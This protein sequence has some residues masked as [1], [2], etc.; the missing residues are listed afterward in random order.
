MQ[1]LNPAVEER[2]HFYY[3]P[4]SAVGEIAARARRLNTRMRWEGYIA[5][6]IA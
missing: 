4:H 1:A 6:I 3:Q 2:P 5:P